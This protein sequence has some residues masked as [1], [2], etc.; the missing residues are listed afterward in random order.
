M[1]G[2]TLLIIVAIFSL[3]LSLIMECMTNELFY[4]RYDPDDGIWEFWF[5][6]RR[7]NRVK[8]EFYRYRPPEFKLREMSEYIQSGH[9]LEVYTVVRD[10]GTDKNVFWH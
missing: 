1:D 2:M 9:S 7:L 4:I 3:A 10:L 6:Y 8:V 5:Q